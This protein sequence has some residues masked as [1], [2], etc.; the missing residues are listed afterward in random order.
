V[1]GFD[2]RRE[3]SGEMSQLAGRGWAEISP[4]N[5]RLTKTGLRFADSAAEMFLR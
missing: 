5:F 3:W 2:L 4:D 1:T